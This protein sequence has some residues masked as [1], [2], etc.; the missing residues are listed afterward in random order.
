MPVIQYTDLTEEQKKKYRL[1][2]NRLGDIAE[3]DIQ[4]L[5]EEL[6]EIDDKWLTDMFKE[7]DLGL[8]E[9]EWN[10]ETEDDAPEVDEEEETI[11]Q[12]GDIF[13]LE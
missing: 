9:K 13:V 2:D 3:Y 10:E 6:K 8:E 11:V 4:N 12:E 7:L 1:L 5:R